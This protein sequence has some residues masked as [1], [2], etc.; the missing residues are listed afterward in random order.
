MDNNQVPE[1]IN[2]IYNDDEKEFG[3]KRKWVKFFGNEPIEVGVQPLD[4]LLVKDM[5]KCPGVDSNPNTLPPHPPIPVILQYCVPS[6]PSTPCTLLSLYPPIPC[7]SPAGDALD[8][9]VT[10]RVGAQFIKVVVPPSNRPV[11]AEHSSVFQV[12]LPLV[13]GKV[14]G[15]SQLLWSFRSKHQLWV[16]QPQGNPPIP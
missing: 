9:C 8:V 14:D 12:L 11:A 10:S 1:R 2:V 5:G 4:I 15:D 6:T 13:E 3:V 7:A 16:Q